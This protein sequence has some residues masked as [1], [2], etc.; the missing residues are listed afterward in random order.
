MLRTIEVSD[1]RRPN[2]GAYRISEP[3]FKPGDRCRLIGEHRHPRTGI[4]EVVV[5]RVDGPYLGSTMD[6]SDAFL[7][8]VREETAG[9]FMTYPCSGKSLELIRSV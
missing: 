8:R 5:E 7:Y 6:L 9:G 4:R 1:I 3:R 2:A